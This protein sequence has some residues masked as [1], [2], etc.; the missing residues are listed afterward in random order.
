MECLQ[1][2]LGYK[3]GQNISLFISP[4]F[5]ELK[6]DSPLLLTSRVD[7]FSTTSRTVLTLFLGPDIG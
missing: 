1:R 7:P 4:G 6:V 3:A 2:V 5:C